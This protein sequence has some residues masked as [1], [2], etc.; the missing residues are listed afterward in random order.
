MKTSCGVQS[1]NGPPFD[2]R[3]TRCGAQR[4]QDG[5]SRKPT[6]LGSF[7]FA[8]QSLRAGREVNTL[9]RYRHRR[10]PWSR[11]PRLRD[12]RISSDHK[13]AD[14]R[15]TAVPR[16]RPL[17]PF[18]TGFGGHCS[19]VTT[20]PAAT[21]RD[22]ARICV[23]FRACRLAHEREA[24]GRT[25]RSAADLAAALRGCDDRPSLCAAGAA[26]SHVFGASQDPV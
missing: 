11:V 25:L 20:L 21:P 18:L 12:R 6:Q 26:R 24:C 14:L 5:N 13:P 23:G 2:L 15:A 4:R 22:A 9:F 3:A 1:S 8:I 10:Q 16:S 17:L 19:E 7:D